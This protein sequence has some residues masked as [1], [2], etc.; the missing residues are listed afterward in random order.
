M[1]RYRTIVADPPWHYKRFVSSPKSH[2]GNPRGDGKPKAIA[3]PYGSM[4]VEEIRALPVTEIADA[5]AALFLW[6]TNRYLPSAFDVMSAWG[7]DYRQ[8]VVWHKTGNPSPFSGSIAPN[9]AEYLL[10]GKRGKPR[11]GK[12]WTSNVIV[13]PAPNV[14]AHSVKPEVF[15]DLIEQSSP[16]PYLEL[17]ARRARFGWDY[18]G[19]QSLG[20]AELAG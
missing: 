15:I 9:H 13:A 7:F 2:A 4:T 11:M 16:G 12:P 14:N 20:T 17:F 10:F 19:D 18:W 3:L 5:E 1:T 8:A 6:A